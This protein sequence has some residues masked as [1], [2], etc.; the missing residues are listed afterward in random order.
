MVSLA[1]HTS[2]STGMRAAE[3]HDPAGFCNFHIIRKR[4][5]KS[6]HC[7]TVTIAVQVTRPT[8]NLR[9]WVLCRIQ[10]RLITREPYSLYAPKHTGGGKISCIITPRAQKGNRG[11]KKSTDLPLLTWH[12][13][14]GAKGQ[15]QPPGCTVMSSPYLHIPLPEQ[16]DAAISLLAESLSLQQVFQAGAAELWMVQHRGF[17]KELLSRSLLCKYN[18]PREVKFPLYT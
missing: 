10:I 9:S 12:V 1:G 14:N 6:K 7:M 13:Y 16:A 4:C 8:A 11:T 5:E 17:A 3:L 2:C 18:S 15:V